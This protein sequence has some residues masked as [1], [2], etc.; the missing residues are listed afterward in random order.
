MPVLPSSLKYLEHLSKRGV[1]EVDI[2]PAVPV[3]QVVIEHLLHA[4]N[5]AG[6]G[7]NKTQVKDSTVI[8]IGKTEKEIEVTE[9]HTVVH[10]S[11]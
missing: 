1:L 11:S 9:E 3:Q 2:D 8:H 10:N 7:Y 5:G 4:M 6:C